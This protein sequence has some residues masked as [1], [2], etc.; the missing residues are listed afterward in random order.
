[1]SEQ[2]QRLSI[3]IAIAFG[4]RI[5][6]HDQQNSCESRYRLLFSNPYRQSLKRI[7]PGMGLACGRVSIAI[8][9]S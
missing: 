4:Q 9:S 6:D 7:A 1:M 8:Y 5:S 2:R 3:A